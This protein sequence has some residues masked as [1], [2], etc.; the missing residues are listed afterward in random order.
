MKIEKQ[1]R[2]YIMPNVFAMLGTSCYI[3]ADT[4]FIS[5]AQGADG[6]TALNLILPI[7]GLIFAV[8]AMIGVGAAT[9]YALHK[10]LDKKDSNLYFS[11]AIIWDLIVSLIFVGLGIF[12]PDLVLKAMGADARI[13]EIG[14]IYLRIALCF[15]PCFILNFVFTSFVRNDGSPKIAMAATLLSSLFNILF[16]YVL[17]FPLKLGMT[18]AA[19]ATGLSPILSMAI[20]MT[21]YLSKRNTIRFCMMIPSIRMLLDSCKL[22]IVAFVGELASG[23]TTLAFNYLLLGLAGNIA[24]AAYGVIANLA[25]VGTAIFNG[26]SQGLQP[27]ASEAY[28]RRDKEAQERIYKH[29]LLIGFILALILVVI[30]WFQA[31]NCV[32]IFNSE[33]SKVMREYGVFGIRIYFL[34][35][36]LASVNIIRAG[37]LSATGCASKSAMIAVMRGI[38]VIVLFAFIF[39]RFF[40]M[41]GVW[42]AY[43]ATEF[44]TLLL[45][46]RKPKT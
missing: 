14:T 2:K 44:F 36:F 32:K 39:S 38:V 20:C 18:G 28:G 3:L 9:R 5:V 16:D 33:N 37:F 45:T 4:F 12:C 11:N 43:P 17:M 25:L 26:V 13:L 1:L 7:Y 19:L 46:S 15:A 8:G 30:V 22:G 10:A 6:I 40:G 34:G 27:L 42:I 35:F 23:I 31:E 24:V 29:S 21:H 41:T